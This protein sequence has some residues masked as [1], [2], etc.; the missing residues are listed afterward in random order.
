[1]ARLLSATR[2]DSQFFKEKQSMAGGFDFSPGSIS[3]S[4]K[5]DVSADI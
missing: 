3:K 2:I 1:M 5:L 4:M